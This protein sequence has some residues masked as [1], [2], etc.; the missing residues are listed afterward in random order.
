MMIVT[1]EL[2]QYR[3]FIFFE[4]VPKSRVRPFAIIGAANQLNANMRSKV[5][6]CKHVLGKYTKMFYASN[7][8]NM[9]LLLTV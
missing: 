6:A 8:E 5:H 1:V 9:L 2:V 4:R 3:I 7:R